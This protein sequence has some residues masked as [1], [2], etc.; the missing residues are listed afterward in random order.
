MSASLTRGPEPINFIEFEQ[1]PYS[2]MVVTAS[3]STLQVWDLLSLSVVWCVKLNV[4][5]LT[6]DPLSEH[7]AAFT[8]DNQLFVFKTE[9]RMPVVKMAATNK[10]AAAN[11][12]MAAAEDGGEQRSSSPP[13][14]AAIFVPRGG[15][16]EGK[17]GAEEEEGRLPSWMEKSKLYYVTQSQELLAID[18]KSS[19][20]SWQTLPAVSLDD[21]GQAL[22]GPYALLTA[23]KVRQESMDEDLVEDINQR[24]GNLVEQSTRKVSEMLII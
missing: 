2:H 13:V 18:V 4:T 9:Q 11:N 5:A 21:S 14:M 23:K 8:A 3:T 1:K 15:E 12:K 16:D 24:M 20:S 10:M 6:A 22:R 17:D 19:T 7:F